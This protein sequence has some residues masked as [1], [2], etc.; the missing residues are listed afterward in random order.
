MTIVEKEYSMNK[1][2]ISIAI[3]SVTAQ[4]INSI[5]VPVLVNYYIKDKDIFGTSGLV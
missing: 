4:L 1:F 2:Q 5:I 3:K